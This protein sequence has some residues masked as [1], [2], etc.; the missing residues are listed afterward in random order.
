MERISTMAL[1]QCYKATVNESETITDAKP[2][3]ALGRF[4]AKWIPVR[5]KKTRQ[6]KSLEPGSDFIR[7]GRVLGCRRRSPAFGFGFSGV[8]LERS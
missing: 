6:N 1:P 5:V 4:R 3:Y 8:H 2:F 7:T